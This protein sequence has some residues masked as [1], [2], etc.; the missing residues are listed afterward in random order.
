MS[1]SLVNTLATLGT[2][3]VIAATAIAALVQLRHA[4]G[5]NQI[6]ALNELREFAESP[7]FQAANVFIRGELTT[8]MQDPEFRHQIEVPSVRTD[9]GRR[10]IAQAHSV[11][12]FYE[13][14]GVLVRAGLIDQ[15]L[16]NRIWS[17]LITTVWQCLAP[18]TAIARRRL[19]D[20]VWE[21]FEYLAVISQDWLAAHP[22]GTYP[23]GTRR[24]ELKDEWFEADKQY[25]A[26]LASA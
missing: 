1:L 25:V 18:Y 12:N 3:V 16:V 10:F 20:V 8:K 14:I 2:F 19:G 6:A 9:D 21:N 15:E 5:S 17:D 26:S 11:G 22:H 7:D 13:D 23:A 24:M 4:R